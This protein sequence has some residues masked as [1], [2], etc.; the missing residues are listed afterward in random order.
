MKMIRWRKISLYL[1]I[2]TII[3]TNS[4]NEDAELEGKVFQ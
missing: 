4:C 1:V 2:V 3:G